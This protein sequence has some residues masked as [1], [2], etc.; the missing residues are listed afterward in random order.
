MHM[1]HHE[2]PAHYGLRTER[3]KLIFF[4]GLPLDAPGA[5]KQTTPPQWELYDLEKDP[6]EMHNVVADPEYASV[7][8]SLKERLLAEKGRVE[9]T[10]E[11]Y[12]KL[13]EVRRTEWKL[14]DHERLE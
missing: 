4:Y 6:H 3:Y 2:N 12:P 10:D 14:L 5:K 11:K 8:K 13:M 1:L 9:D 7:L